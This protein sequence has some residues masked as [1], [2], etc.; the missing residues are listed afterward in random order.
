M[1]KAILSLIIVCISMSPSL[2]GEPKKEKEPFYDQ[3]SRGVIRLEHYEEVIKEGSQS[4]KRKNIPDGTAFFVQS[5]EEL[6]I[7]SARHVVEKN[8]DLHARVRSKNKKTG[9]IEVILLRLQRNRWIFHTN[10][11]DKDT[12]YVDVASQK[13]S[14]I[15]DRVIK[16]FR[17]EPKG[18]DNYEKNLL[19]D[20]DAIP[21]KSILVF[22]FPLD[23]GFKLLEQRPFGRQ[24]ILSM[25]A[26]KKFLMIDDSK[27]A[28]ER[29][30]LI[31][32]EMFPGNS[33][34][35]V[36]NQMNILDPKPRLLGIVIASNVRM[37][38]AVMEPVSRIREVLD[39]AKSQS[40]EGVNCWYLLND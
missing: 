37:D 30:V 5:G 39:L 11:G 21:P 25:V 13:I 2:A 28:E 31:D 7:I 17:Y 19:P 1:T 23:I 29:C 6:F 24:G 3:I 35:P 27:F 20:K 34:S 26:G 12:K 36:I 14:W 18:S 33:G 16:A 9:K 40:R 10:N 32:S 4:R 22:G 38:Y 8:Y 15:K